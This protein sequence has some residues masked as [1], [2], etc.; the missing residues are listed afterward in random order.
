MSDLINLEIGGIP[1]TMYL[2]VGIT[3]GVLAYTTLTSEP[4]SES[5]PEPESEP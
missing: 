5:E 1:I 4:E 2:L 3:T